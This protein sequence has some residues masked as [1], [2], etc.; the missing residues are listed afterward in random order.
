M[1]LMI[2]LKNHVKLS[3]PMQG[4]NRATHLH[5]TEGDGR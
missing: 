4:G 5:G 1:D 2:N 3:G